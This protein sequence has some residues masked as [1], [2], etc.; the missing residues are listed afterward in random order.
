MADQTTTGSGSKFFARA[1]Q[2]AETGNWDFA[3]EMYLEGIQREPSNLERGHKPLREVA[4][5]RTAMGQKPA[6]LLE[7]LK[8]RGTKDPIE[9]LINAEYLLSKEP[10][11]IGQMIAVLKA[12]QNAKLN[13]VV[14]WICDILFDAQ[15]LAKRKD[16]RVLLQITQ[17][18]HDIERYESAAKACNLAHQTDPNDQQV[19]DILK[20]L[21]TKATIQKGKYDGKSDFTQNV[22]DAE[23]QKELAEGDRMVQTADFVKSQIDKA[24]QEYLLNQK[25]EGKI[26]SFVDYLLKTEDETFENEAIDVLAKA[27]QDSGSYRY[28]SRIG[29]VRIRQMNRR[30]RKLLESGDK[31]AAAEQ[32]RSLLAFELEEFT[33]RSVNYPTDLGIKFELGRRQLLAGKLDEA[34]GSFQQAQR[35]PRRHLRAMNYLGQSFAAKGWYTEAAETFEKALEEEM[36]EDRAKEIRYNFGDVVEKIGDG[37]HSAAEKMAQ[38]EKARD[39]FSAVAQIDYGYKDVRTRVEN[40]R[41]KIEQARNDSA[42]QQ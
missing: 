9:T 30:Y 3:I 4:L 35:D 33:E 18:W 42:S 13:D 37:R 8:R 12:A 17:A 38:Y 26:N 41:K 2:V 24:R 21:V 34:I 10:G 19:I 27:H 6:G 31:A 15:Q 25:V 14:N 29:D 36:G 28:K 39:Q 7:Q 16:K 40:L 22:R 23:K 1:E 11:S 32:A 20:D 5:K